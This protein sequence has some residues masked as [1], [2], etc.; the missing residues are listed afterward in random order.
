MNLRYRI[1]PYI[2]YSIL[3]YDIKCPNTVFYRYWRNS[4]PV[5]IY[6][7][8]FYGSFFSNPNILIRNRPSGIKIK[9]Y[10]ET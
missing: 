7:G 3:G 9:Q 6:K 10:Y 1:I 5:G 4:L 2:G 8:K